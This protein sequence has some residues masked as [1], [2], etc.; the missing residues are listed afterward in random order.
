[1]PQLALPP[2]SG[3]EGDSQVVTFLVPASMFVAFNALALLVLHKLHRRTF[4]SAPRYDLS[5]ICTG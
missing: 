4:P 2:C 3:K 1:L 5:T